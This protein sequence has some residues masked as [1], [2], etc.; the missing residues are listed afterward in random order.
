MKKF[1]IVILL[2]FSSIYIA[3]KTPQPP[4]S[5]NYQRGVEALLENDIETGLEYLNKE[6]EESP[7]NGY[8]FLWIGIGRSALQE[9]GKAFT[10]LNKAM[11]YL[12]KKDATYYSYA[13][14]VRAQVHL[15]LEDSIAALE[16]LNKAI[17]INPTSENYYE[18]RGDLLFYLKDYE[19]SDKDY[20]QIIAL[21]PG[22][23]MG[24]MGLG[25]NLKEQGEY[26]KAIELFS[27]VIKIH[28]NY[29]SAYSF[30]AEAYLKMNKYNEA[31]DDIISALSLDKDTKA[32]Y[33]LL[34]NY[35]TE[36]AL[37]VLKN[38]LHIEKTKEPN[39]FMWYFYYAVALEN[40][41]MYR[42]A[43]EQYQ[44]CKRINADPMFDER[45]SRCYFRLGNM[46]HALDFVQ[47]A[48]TMDSTDMDLYELRAEI[49]GEM[50]EYAKA[51]DDLTKCIET[52][53]E[54]ANAYYRRGYYKDWNQQY[55]AAIEDYTL[56]LTLDSTYKYVYIARA[57][58]YMDI[59]KDELAK[60]DFEKILS[61]DT[62]PDGN[63]CAAFAYHFLGN[64]SLAIDFVQRTLQEDSTAN[65][66][67]ACIYALVGE[68]DSAV[69]YLRKALEAGFV[70][71]HHLSIDPDFDSIR[72]DER[73]I[74][75]VEEYR[76]KM[77]DVNLSENTDGIGD[78]RIV[79][80]PFTA[81]N[82]VTKV[83]CTINGLP[84][85]FVFDTG[86]SDVTISQ[87]EANF[88][89]KNGYL[90]E[91]DIIGKQHYQ[92]ADGNISVGTVINLSSINFG[93]LT[94]TDV[95][96]S[97]VK[98]Q[99]APLLLGQTVLQRLGKI[100]IDNANRILKITT[101]QTV[102]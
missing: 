70:R 53:P 80:I 56:A 82:G 6:L 85:N 18:Q 55:E 100:E 101:K 92:T 65:Y 93:G 83:N 68:T 16:D 36:K 72:D 25:R 67:A 13:Y 43:I 27:Y 60:A 74:S 37:A 10:A 66:N 2:I 62:V 47:S 39:N 41:K 94:L 97:V 81:A 28:P 88:M 19:A 31:T 20:Q 58:S 59:S 77:E 87:V 32:E 52:E 51:I 57:R 22:S 50:G 69:F 76:Q 64:D 14:L 15:E 40:N 30:R 86:A 75:L 95:R 48:M 42:E 35:K 96:A 33:L 78:D 12:P 44:S 26:A 71:M 1:I 4:T 45:I 99:N 11:Q 79:E 17:K 24:Y 73:F 21:N 98:S 46:A 63:A 7:K 5:Y 54:D 102:D 90:S 3:A 34:E 38:K 8:A 61:F 89:F 49:Y 23:F 91:K 29:S 84:L 9:Y